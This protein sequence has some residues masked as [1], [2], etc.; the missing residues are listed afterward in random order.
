MQYQ[1]FQLL[2]EP[3]IK[4]LQE[5]G[6]ER[7]VSVLEL[8]RDAHHIKGLANELPAL[9]AALLRLL[10]AMLYP[11]V[12]RY[13]PEGRQ[14]ALRD[15]DE[16]IERWAAYW[17]RKAFPAELITD[18]L[19]S[20]ED[21]FYLFHS[22]R[23]FYQV[24]L[25][26]EVIEIDGK[27]YKPTQ[28][29]LR[30]L[31][32]DL[33]ESR[34]VVRLFSGRLNKASLS[35]AEAARWL[36]YLNGYDAAPAGQSGNPETGS[37]VK[38]YGTPW[39]S[40][41]GLLWISGNNLFETLM[42]NLCF[43]NAFVNSDVDFGTCRPLWEREDAFHLSQLPKIE[44]PFPR[45]LCTLY[46]MQ[47]RRVFLL[48]DPDREL[49]TGYLLWSGQKLD[50][51]HAMLEPMTVWRRQGTVWL[52]KL[53]DPARQMW[54]DLSSIILRD[55]QD[56]RPGLM[57]WVDELISARVLQGT[58]I[59]LQIAGISYTNST[60]VEHVFADSLQIHANLL[61]RLG[62]AWALHIAHALSATNALVLHLV[63]LVRDLGKAAGDD[64]N[65]A[66]IRSAIESAF[67]ML[68]EPFRRWLQQVN[69]V[70]MEP[71]EQCALWI[72]EARKRIRRA[73]AE[74]VRLVGLK[75]LVGRKIKE[76]GRAQAVL[77]NQIKAAVESGSQIGYRPK[78][79]GEGG[80]E[81][82]YTA[83]IA[84]NRF[85]WRTKAK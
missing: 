78:G 47:F 77:H 48:R 33:A 74:Q 57:R 46:T 20:Y 9:D 36:V 52:P 42:L 34:G 55:E 49:V 35:Y 39:L 62:Q 4:V 73:G 66:K 41:I 65:A 60:A 12:S 24:P 68:D 15:P 10:L 83:A 38:R 64:D 18:Y 80:R 44:P 75:A 28:K 61:S 17:R 45:D 40:R 81:E 13:T 5:D 82:H 23:P 37:R 67:F 14:E 54:R 32:G 76:D 3:W 53:H 50:A 16:A 27:K 30:S 6:Q 7:E 25:H 19:N 22:S 56:G 59:S 79:G 69:P 71:E 31:I 58:M 1:A 43:V 84:F 70:E 72:R 8:F 2:Q 85:L 26:A 63:S 51:E 11:V 21:H 29:P